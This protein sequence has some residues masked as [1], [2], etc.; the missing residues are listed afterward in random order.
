MIE[1]GLNGSTFYVNKLLIK[2]IPKLGHY[3]IFLGRACSVRHVQE[4]S[5]GLCLISNNQNDCI[6]LFDSLR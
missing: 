4:N 1:L 3:V 5:I 2:D 6:K